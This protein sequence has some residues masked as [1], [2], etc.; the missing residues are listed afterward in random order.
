MLSAYSQNVSQKPSVIVGLLVICIV[1]MAAAF[2]YATILTKYDKEY[3]RLAG[4]QRVLALR[5]V[6]HATEA[7]RARAEAF[8]LLQNAEDNYEQALSQLLEGNVINGL[9]PSPPE[10]QQALQRVVAD[11]REFRDRINIILQSEGVLRT[12]D[13]FVSAV[14]EVMPNLL[15]LSGQLTERLIA[16]KADPRLIHLASRQLLLGQRIATQTNQVLTGG[17]EGSSATADFERDSK[18]FEAALD[19][20]LDGNGELGLR[21]INDRQTR[22]MLHDIDSLYDA[23]HE[24]LN[25]ILDKSPQLFRAQ[26]AANEMLS[27]VEPLLANTTALVRV[28]A[29]LEKRRKLTTIAGYALGGTALALLVGL[30]WALMQA[31][32]ARV[33]EEAAAN[34][35]TQN[36]VLRLLNEISPLGKGDLTVTATVSEEITGAIADAINYSIDALRQL[37]MAVKHMAGEVA[38]SAEE[39]QATALHL[40]RASEQQAGEL[41][42]VTDAVADIAR[43][44][45]RI[46]AH[47]Q[48]SAE[49]ANESV[50]TASQGVMAVL[51]T[52]QNMNITR[53]HIRETSS[54]IK[55]LGESTQ[56]IGDIVEIINDIA[57]QT[58]VL[59]LNAAIQ[60]TA[61]GDQG[62]GFATLADEVQQLA[63]RV[64]QATG[65]IETLVTAIVADTG[66]AVTSMEQST[67][68]VLEGAKLAED[69][70][71][72]LIRI[73][74]VSKHLAELINGISSAAL[75]LNSNATR[76]SQTMQRV[77]SVTSQNL[78]GTKQTALL[79]GRLTELAREQD[80]TVKG[81]KLPSE[82]GA[83]TGKKVEMEISEE[84]SEK[85]LS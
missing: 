59:A 46:T 66:Q 60:A 4:E 58:N 75:Q 85:I 18:A 33:D 80:D 47:A 9:P 57:E 64:G 10:A 30:G 37:V 2:G 62:L 16:S 67:S 61:A 11:W 31:A 42:H 27:Q 51:N 83:T 1:L 73:E 54:R 29:G 39:T 5:M 13:N 50:E 38:I 14:A 84:K 12:L 55:R 65:K 72:A 19:S 53:D 76:I 43:A 52:I 41:N 21:R 81:F 45:E 40:T 24:V 7:S 44:I 32:R 48:E 17:V 36:A 34:R 56:E 69:A 15:A 28:Y 22:R 35:R 26:Q 63:E 8:T 23:M 79:T 20:M 82:A 49:V 70:G 78:A 6:K 68:D 71:D 74:M 3:I 77:Q 25:Q